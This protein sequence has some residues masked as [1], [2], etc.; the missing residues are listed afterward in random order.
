MASQDVE[1]KP[2][3]RTILAGE[4]VHLASA[5]F[6]DDVVGLLETIICR[7]G[8]EPAS[9]EDATIVLVHPG[10]SAYNP[11]ATV[12]AL[13]AS[14]PA[15]TLVVAYH[16]LSVCAHERAR[17]PAQS[18][19]PLLFYHPDA[20]LAHRPLR[21]F[22]SLNVARSRVS[23]NAEDARAAVVAQ[24][25]RH[26]ALVVTR[27]SHA[28]LLIVEPHTRFFKDVL[29]PERARRGRLWQRFAERAWVDACIAKRELAW[30]KTIDGG[31][32]GDEAY[33]SFA[34]DEPADRKGPGR[35]TGTPRNEYTPEDDDFV[36]RYL[37]AYHHKGS[38]GS[39]K[40]FRTLMEHADAYPIADRHTAQSWHER[41][42][43]NMG[44]FERRIRRYIA[45]DVDESL[46]TR[47]ERAK[48]G[49]ARARAAGQ[50]EEEDE[51]EDGQT[52]EEGDRPGPSGT[53]GAAEVQKAEGAVEEEQA[54]LPQQ[55]RPLVAD[56]DDEVDDASAPIAVMETAQVPQPQATEPR[57]VQAA[58]EAQPVTP[59]ANEAD[60]SA[61]EPEQSAPEPS[62]AGEASAVHNGV[63]DADGAAAI[64]SAGVDGNTVEQ[65]LAAVPARRASSS[66]GHTPSARRQLDADDAALDDALFHHKR[67][68]LSEPVPLP[69]AGASPRTDTRRVVG[70]RATAP[71]PLPHET[72]PQRMTIP[73][74]LELD[75]RGVA[76]DGAVR[77]ST[78]GLTGS[79]SGLGLGLGVGSASAS[80]SHAARYSTPIGFARTIRDEILISSSR[81]RRHQARASVSG[82]PDTVFADVRPPPA[83]RPVTPSPAH[84][85]PPAPPRAA[86]PPPMSREEREA[87]VVRGREIAER[88]RELYRAQI[89]AVCDR[90][91]LEPRDVVRHIEKFKADGAKGWDEMA[92]R[93]EQS[94]AA[95]RGKA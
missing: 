59:A 23:E 41:V 58:V 72:P 61:P 50:E 94:L 88:G 14:A 55:R 22:V 2:G 95:G 63:S 66:A 60:L 32:G 87:S 43:K 75:V 56:S 82:S 29:R 25:E 64:H 9:L 81:R 11:G 52:E 85:T 8:A 44:S 18:L 13:R 68:R 91:G 71:L 46:K 48:A 21:T 62:A 7:L 24:L 84:T 36:C 69:R 31:G 39:R 49:Q 38:W 30:R 20:S 70:P 93:F 10:S 3:D 35:P 86:P 28:D 5:Q 34:E 19:P 90:F 4:R 83:R 16:W 74:R 76:Q 78:P 17:W 47:G 89:R 27:R 67:P 79:G 40:T 26:G 42:K 53:T 54:E 15:L 65:D 80:A 77:L 73:L 33:D 51:E 6:V 1:V 12:E 45:D 57:H 37:A 92:T